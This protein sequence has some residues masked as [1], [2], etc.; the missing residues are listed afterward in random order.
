MT[1]RKLLLPKK[2]SCLLGFVTIRD[3]TNYNFVL[4][5]FASQTIL[6]MFGAPAPMPFL[7][8]SSL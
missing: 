5:Y 4:L 1:Q 3:R 7:G 2:A 8:V 6:E